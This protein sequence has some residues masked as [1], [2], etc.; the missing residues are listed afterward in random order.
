MRGRSEA[1]RKRWRGKIELL[2]RQGVHIQDAPLSVQIQR[3]QEILSLQ[4]GIARALHENP[5][6]EARQM[7]AKLARKIKQS[8]GDSS[9]NPALNAMKQMLREKAGAPSQKND[10]KLPS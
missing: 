1:S 3:A 2:R 7:I 10:P 9:K 6:N 4:T 5:D 8:G